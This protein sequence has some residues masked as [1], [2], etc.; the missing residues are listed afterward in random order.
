MSPESLWA[1]KRIC[2]DEA[3]KRLGFALGISITLE[4]KKGQRLILVSRPKSG[5]TSF[6]QSIIG[7]LHVLSGSVRFGGR[8]GYLP[9]VLWS[10]KLSVRDNILFGEP[11]DRKKLD[12]VY[13]MV[14][15][16]AD[17]KYFKQG[18]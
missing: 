13:R 7:N 9:Q 8:I 3:V 15:L 1:D 16:K 17:L 6:L 5:K 14:L 4:L 11:Y 10:R 12:I 18:E 2:Y